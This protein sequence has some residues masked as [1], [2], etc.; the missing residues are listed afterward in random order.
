MY[1]YDHECE[2]E[3][4]ARVRA[5]ELIANNYWPCYFFKSDTTG[6]KD[7]EEFFTDSEN[8]DMDQFES[9]GV[10]KNQLLFNEEKLDQFVDGIETLRKQ[11]MW[12][13]QDIIDLYFKILPEFLHKE[14]GKYLDQRM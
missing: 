3:D 9:V 6:E 10:I 14:T 4:E 12:D 11:K 2:N 7:F 1:N 8:L 5:N 13:K